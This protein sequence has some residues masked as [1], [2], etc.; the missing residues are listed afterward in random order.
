VAG[1]ESVKR[2]PAGVSKREPS[3]PHMGPKGVSEFSSRSQMSSKQ[4]TTKKGSGLE[5]QAS[6]ATVP[7]ATTGSG[8]SAK[9]VAKKAGSTLSGT[10]TETGEEGVKRPPVGDSNREPLRPQMSSNGVSELSSRSQR[11]SKEVAT[12]KG[13]GLERQACSATVPGAVAASET[14]AGNDVENP[15]SPSNS[16]AG[17]DV[18]NS[19]SPSSSDDDFDHVT[20]STTLTT[21]TAIAISN[22]E[23]EEEMRDRIL[24]QPVQAYPEP[25]ERYDDKSRR[26][27]RRKLWYALMCACVIIAVAATVG[28]VV[29]TRDDGNKLPPP[30]PQLPPPPPP[31]GD[32]GGGGGGGS[33]NNTPAPT[34]PPRPPPPPPDGG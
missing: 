1:E 9:K 21:V 14:F 10:T 13:S 16:D 25:I 27:H 24:G 7:G 3:Q 8:N 18:E 11:N 32:G 4:V 29:G 22:E 28:V 20:S 34:P 12:K 6:S 33:G 2:L 31:D 23:L 5:R 17:N 26:H 15:A 30:P 19:A